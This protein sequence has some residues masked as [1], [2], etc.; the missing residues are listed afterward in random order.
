MLAELNSS[1]SGCTGTE[2][3]PASPTGGGCGAW[4]SAEM[5]RTSNTGKTEGRE[6][7]TQLGSGQERNHY[8]RL[9]PSGQGPL[10][11]RED[12]RPEA[13]GGPRFCPPS[14]APSLWEPCWAQSLQVPSPTVGTSL[15]QGSLC[16][17]ASVLSTEGP[18]LSTWG[19]LRAGMGYWVQLGLCRCLPAS[20]LSP[21]YPEKCTRR[22]LQEEGGWD[23]R[24]SWSLCECF[25]E[26]RLQSPFLCFPGCPGAHGDGC[27]AGAP[28]LSSHRQTLAS[29]PAA[30]PACPLASR[31]H[32]TCAHCHFRFW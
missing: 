26:P 10:P 25:P 9:Y 5:S 6:V 21:P 19:V 27:L 4:P 14:A 17:G 30:L 22:L 24:C 11:S 13:G 18:P 7:P 15:A 29:P 28:L 8:V 3:P 12:V 1:C 23:P 32:S 2:A 20:A 31:A 16:S